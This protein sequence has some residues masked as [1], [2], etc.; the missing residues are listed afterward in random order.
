MNILKKTVK[1]YIIVDGFRLIWFYIR[2]LVNN[3]PI[4][5]GNKYS[6]FTTELGFKTLKSRASLQQVNY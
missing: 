1:V 5:G 4:H 3:N 2:L 6:P